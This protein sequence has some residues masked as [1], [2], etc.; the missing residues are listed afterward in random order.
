MG[1][2][3]G[4]RRGLRIRADESKYFS[5]DMVAIQG[6]QRFDINIYDVGTASDSGG[7]IGLVFG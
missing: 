4:T 2:W 1:C 3:F 6:T 5:E 7:I